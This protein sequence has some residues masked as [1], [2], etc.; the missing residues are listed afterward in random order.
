MIS[1]HFDDSV[2]GAREVQAIARSLHLLAYRTGSVSQDIS[3]F[4]NHLIIIIII[5][6]QT[7]SLSQDVC[8]F[9][10][11]QFNIIISITFV[12]DENMIMINFED[13][14]FNLCI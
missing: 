10:N 8:G 1:T 11:Y 12:K 2:P 4:C 6:Y 13:K 7:R 14:L 3:G 5:K 9:C